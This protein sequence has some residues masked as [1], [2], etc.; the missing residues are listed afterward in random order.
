MSESTYSEKRASS[1]EVSDIGKLAG[2]E[3]GVYLEFK[4]LSEF[5]RAGK[6]SPDLFAKELSETVSAFLNSDGGVVLIGVQ[7]DKHNK[8]RKTEVLRRLEAWSIDQTFEHLDI[9]LTASQVRDIIYGNI[10]PK[11]T[12]V[13]VKELTV[14]I[15]KAT[16]IVFVITVP[17]SQLGA[18]QSVKTLLYYR[19]QADGDEPMLDFEIRTVNSRRA[20]PLLH[21]A[22]KVS[23]TVGSHFEEDWKESSVDMEK[24]DAGEQRFYRANLVFAV[25][26]L[27]RGT[28]NIARFDIGIPTPW[29]V[30]HH[31]PDGTDVGATWVSR[32]GLRYSIGEEVT[33]FWVPEKCHQIP[34]QYRN[35]RL[36]K[37]I[38]A[39]QEVIYSG[40]ETPGHPIW[41]TSGRRIIGV[42]RLER[43]NNANVM[44]FSWLPWRAFAGEMME[45]RGAVLIKENGN[46]LCAFNYEM[47]EVSWCHQAEDEQ[48][49]DELKQRFQAR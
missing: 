39:W 27:G 25:S 34:N 32:S 12:G 45:I 42:I 49:F 38:L 3:E 46:K 9:S 37:Q 33:V 47:D 4:K 8:D 28:A 5:V 35:R 22:C 16:V 14:P 15:G 17:I 44:P 40:N 43:Q 24:V 30:Q 41:P 1:W 29:R 48:K 26:N 10:V 21:L 18:H 20:G 6:F 7:T 19:R 13:E 23:N 11:P 2:T 31:S 36:W